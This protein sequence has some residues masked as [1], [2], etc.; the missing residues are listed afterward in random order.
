MHNG[1]LFSV[2]FFSTVCHFQRI[3]TFVVTQFLVFMRICATGNLA[4]M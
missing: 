1:L 4:A 2:Y 3:I